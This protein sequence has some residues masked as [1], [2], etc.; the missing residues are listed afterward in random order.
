MVSERDEEAR[1]ERKED[2]RKEA[3]PKLSPMTEKTDLLEYL[4]MSEEHMDQKEIY[5]QDWAVWTP[6]ASSK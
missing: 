5:T 4:E 1:Q 2:K 3:I 6:H